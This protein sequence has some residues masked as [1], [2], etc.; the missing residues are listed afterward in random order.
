MLTRLPAVL[1][2]ATLAV[3]QARLAQATWQP[4][5]RS[6]GPQARQVKANEQLD[7]SDPAAAELQTLV[8]QAL[9]RQPLF[10]SAALPKRVLPPQFNRYGAELNRYGDHVDQAIRYTASGQRLRTDL[11]ATLFLS[12]PEAYD[13][14]ELVIQ[15]A[16]GEE[17]VKLAAGS[18]LLYPGS[19]VHRVEPVTRGVR[20]A[21]FFWVESLVRS[22][23]RRRLLFDMDMALMA[24]RERHGESAETVALTG[25]YHNL[26]REWADT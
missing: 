10:L 25:S 1:D 17:R 9:E 14:G 15:H 13:G 23:A 24:L 11:S 3:V 5:A 7:P 21:S 6:A 20:L 2:P 4:G 8:L 18:L 22:D 26:L 16:F 19:S 12:E